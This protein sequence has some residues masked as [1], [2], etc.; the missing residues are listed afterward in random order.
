MAGDDKRLYGR[1]ARVIVSSPAAGND[2]HGTLRDEL[3]IN[4]GD[5]ADGKSLRVEFKIERSSSKEPNSS[6]ITI[7]NLSPDARAKLQKKGNKVTLEAGYDDS[8]QSR[9]FRGDLRTCD[10]KLA[11]G[12]WMSTLHLGDGERSYKF[13]RVQQ[14]FAPGATAKD[15]L[16]YM[17]DASGLQIGN[18]PDVLLDLT[19]TY[20][21]GYAVSGKWS[22]AMAKF[23]R[24]IG[25]RMA[26]HD[27]TLQLLLPGGAVRS[28]I[29]EISPETGLINSPEFG[30]PAKKGAPALI[31]F[32]ALLR[33]TTVGAKVR[34]KSRAHDG[35]V[36]V[37][38]C[39]FDGDTHGQNWYT[40]YEGVLEK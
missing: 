24:S 25:Y 33:P 30:T 26:I 3:E 12:D 32:V 1:V 35:N 39:S 23:C 5:G 22:D 28:E 38:K 2:F 11:N 36:I 15:V 16:R 6:T 27:E 10:H 9:I 17:G 20:D 7:F 34:L 40:H 4:G 13:A 8:G 29:P 37:R 31:K 21:Q 19:V 14:S 18:V